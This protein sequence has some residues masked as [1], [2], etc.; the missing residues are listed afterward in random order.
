[1]DEKLKQLIQESKALSETQRLTYLELIK[2]IT[3]KQKEELLKIFEEG[4]KGIQEV[5]AKRDQEKSEINKKYIVA[6]ADKF[7]TEEKAAMASEEKQEKE[8]SEQLLE[9]LHKV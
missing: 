8:D 5:E 2:H 6:V 4:A 9:Q 7:K 1:M 3:P